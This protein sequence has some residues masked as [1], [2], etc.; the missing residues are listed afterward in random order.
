[1][2]LNGFASADTIAA[3]VVKIEALGVGCA[4]HN[5][6]LRKPAEIADLV[7]ATTTPFVTGISW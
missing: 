1:M 3:S 7:S 4:H 2:I 6:D 5:A